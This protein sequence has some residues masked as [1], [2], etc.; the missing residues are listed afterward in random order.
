MLGKTVHVFQAK[1]TEKTGIP[2]NLGDISNSC[3]NLA[4]TFVRTSSQCAIYKLIVTTQV[5]LEGKIKG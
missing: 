3:W 1:D 5:D 2:T 4:F